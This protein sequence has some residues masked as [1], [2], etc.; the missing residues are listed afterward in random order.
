MS[1]LTTQKVCD[2][3]L[4][5]VETTETTS[6]VVFFAYSVISECSVVKIHFVAAIPVC[7]HSKPL[8]PAFSVKRT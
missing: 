4:G 3:A 2:K 5:L 6:I 7:L 8:F 1:C